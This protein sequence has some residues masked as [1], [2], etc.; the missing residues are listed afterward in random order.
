MATIGIKGIRLDTIAI[1]PT[2]EGE[3]LE[4]EYSLISTVDKVLAKQSVGGYNG[5]KV[6]PS[7]ATI[8]ALRAFV[9]AYKSDINVVIG[10]DAV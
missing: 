3:T 1:K 4:A 10:L 7:P 8:Q 6:Q 2:E 5:L 9:A